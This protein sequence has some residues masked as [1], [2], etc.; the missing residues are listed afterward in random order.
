MNKL[1]LID[2]VA[3]L[4]EAR[5]RETKREIDLWYKHINNVQQTKSKTN[6]E[7]N[8]TFNRKNLINL[9]KT[10]INID[11]KECFHMAGQNETRRDHHKL[12]S[13]I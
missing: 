4:S 8:K 1:S 13:F 11:V 7:S 3:W 2:W 10:D 9:N 6:K 5:N 12:T